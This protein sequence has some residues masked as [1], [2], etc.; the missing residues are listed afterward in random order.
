MG[1]TSTSTKCDQVAAET[2][3]YV[4]NEHKIERLIATRKGGE[5]V[6]S[7][8]APAGSRAELNES[9]LASS[10]DHAY[11]RLQDW[12]IASGSD[13][14]VRLVD[15]FSG[16]GIMTLGVWEACRAL[17]KRREPLL[18]VDINAAALEVYRRNF[19]SSKIDST[20]VEKL[21]NGRTGGRITASERSLAA[22]LGSVDMVI[23]GPPCQGHSNL[24][25]HTRRRD[26]KNALYEKMSRMAEVVGPTFVI[27]ENVSA[28]L[29]DADMVVDKTAES[30]LRLGYSVDEIIIDAKSVGV[31]QKRRRHAIVA[32]LGSLPD[33]NK[34][35]PKYSKPIRS[36]E[37]AIADLTRSIEGIGFD[38]ASSPNST[39]RERIDFLFDNNLR[40]LPDHE[41]PKCHRQ[42]QH[43][44][45]SVYGRLTWKEPA[46]T[47]TTG[48]SCMGQGRYVHPSQRRTLTPHEAAR[49]QFI[50]DFFAFDSVAKR[51]ALSEMI[52]NAVPTKISYLICLEL[53][54]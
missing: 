9:V 39:N 1:H 2:Y 11:L 20:P 47:I 40:D 29:H 37:W 26:P 33:F 54:R 34:E 30:L 43:S 15:L 28:V 18:A 51:T 19:P 38:G 44:Y 41:R 10:F 42:K 35:L 50:P 23:G 21:L 22:A 13:E 17:N 5:A 8:T 6:T 46:P 24:N 53:L 3:R 14:G 25:N 52:G 49:L 27:I 32:S 4:V 12:P 16:C 7:I 31:P 45:K 48:F 36:V